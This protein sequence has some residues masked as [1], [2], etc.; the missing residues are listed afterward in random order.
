MKKAFIIALTLITTSSSLAQAIY[1]DF[2]SE[3]LGETR[4]LK[5]QLPRNFDKEY[6]YGYPLVV[7]LDGDY[8]FE[9]VSGNIDYQAY[10]EDIPDCVIVG[11][12]QSKSRDLDFLYDEYS[13]FPTQDGADFYEFI[14]QEILPYMKVNYNTS[15]FRIIVG[16]DL[17]ANFINYFLFKNEPLFKAYISLSPDLA[18]EMASR[19]Q[20]KF[21]S[22]TQQTFYYVATSDGDIKQL[23]QDIL[24]LDNNLK[25]ID[26][27]KLRYKFDDFSDASHYSLVGRGIPKALNDIF[28]LYRP[29]SRKEYDEKVLTYEGSPYEYLMKKYDDIKTFYGFEKQ[30]V[31]NDIRAIAAASKKKDNL[32]S[33]Q[34]IAKLAEREYSDSMLSTYYS[35]MYHEMAGNLKKALRRYQAGLLLEPS[36]FVDKDL[37]L[38]KMYDL[39]EELKN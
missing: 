23:R 9:P 29:I 28:Y 39:E 2:E 27:E 34:N 26:N 35:G 5:I 14:G 10:W 17:G 15:N 25:G 13:F 30:V 8:M 33:M 7:V 36:Q 3:R 22:I 12:K 20:E 31:E 4:K 1:E 16:H 38:D 21:T 24:E 19:L 11:I 37:L 18:P 6:K 32:D